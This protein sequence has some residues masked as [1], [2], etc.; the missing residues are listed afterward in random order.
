MLGLALKKNKCLEHLD[1]SYNSLK[2]K[3]TSVLANALIYND[4]LRYLSLDGNTLGH[5]GAQAMVAAIQASPGLSP[6]AH[7][8]YLNALM[9]EWMNE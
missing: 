5:V 4:N 2:P 1:L 6:Y 7:I 9:N 3:A 8:V